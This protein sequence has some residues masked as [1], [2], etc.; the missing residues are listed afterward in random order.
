MPVQQI[1]YKHVKQEDVHTVSLQQH[2]C[3]RPQPLSHPVIMNEFVHSAWT[4]RSPDCVCDSH[5]RIYIANKLRCALAG[6]RSFPQQDDLG[7]LRTAQIIA[8]RLLTLRLG[9]DIVSHCQECVATMHCIRTMNCLLSMA[10]NYFTP[11]LA[12]ILNKDPSPKFVHDGWLVF[13]LS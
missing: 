10:T 13:H 7:L 5:A 9:R 2:Q 6:V 8:V 3:W 4:E 11:T 1:C 12:A